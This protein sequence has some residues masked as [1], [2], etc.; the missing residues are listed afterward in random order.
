MA[1]ENGLIDQLGDIYD[2]ES[3]LKDELGEDIEVCW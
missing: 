3:Y 2:V 1:L